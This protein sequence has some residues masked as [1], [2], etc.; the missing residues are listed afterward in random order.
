MQEEE[1]R[2]KEN[3]RLRIYYDDVTDVVIINDIE[4]SGCLFRDL[5]SFLRPG[6]LFRLI[7]RSDGVIAIQNM[8]ASPFTYNGNP[9][10]L[11]ELRHEYGDMGDKESVAFTLFT[12]SGERRRFALRRERLKEDV[13]NVNAWLKEYADK[14]EADS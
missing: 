1:V 2:Q 12:R 13:D 8:K 7:S 14:T 4:Y 3:Q 6:Q 9:L 5:A 11:T 10:Y